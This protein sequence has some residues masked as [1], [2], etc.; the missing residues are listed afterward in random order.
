[1]LSRN[2]GLETLLPDKKITD[3]LSK[4]NIESHPAYE[5]VKETQKTIHQLFEAAN[6]GIINPLRRKRV[7][8]NL[9]KYL[10][11]PAGGSWQRE[12]KRRFEGMSKRGISKR[13]SN[14]KT[15]GLKKEAVA[16]FVIGGIALAI[17]AAG[18]YAYNYYNGYKVYAEAYPELADKPAANLIKEFEGDLDATFYNKD[19]MGVLYFEALAYF[20]AFNHGYDI[21][22]LANALR[23][24]GVDGLEGGNVVEKL[25]EVLEDDEGG[26]FSKVMEA[27]RIG[28]AERSGAKKAVESGAAPEGA[29]QSAAPQATRA[30]GSYADASKIM[31]DKGYLSSPQS[32][33]TPEFDK[34]FRE[35]VDAATKASPEEDDTTMID[36]QGWAEVAAKV[37]FSGNPKGALQAVSALNNFAPKKSTARESRDRFVK[38]AEAR[39][40]RIRGEIMK[41]LTPA[42]KA[43]IRRNKMREI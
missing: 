32:S 33:W 3:V 35:F 1:L 30:G 21:T 29:G 12:A 34:A 16:W 19:N 9:E 41:N 23:E 26:S 7:V 2:P 15:D 24:R 28:T 17:G 6:P 43:T 5:A 18:W 8:E 13:A 10:A 42:E 40:A 4:R 11:S 20:L 39:K 22:M 14:L 25:K 38:L 31:I 27:I 36:G 37:G